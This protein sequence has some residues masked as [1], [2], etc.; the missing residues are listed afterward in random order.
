ME[1]FITSIQL[2]FS[3]P[4]N[5]RFSRVPTKTKFFDCSFL[6]AADINYINFSS[7]IPCRRGGGVE[8]IETSF[9]FFEFSQGEKKWEWANERLMP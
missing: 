9:M 1:M 5:T 8:D 7:G 2:F 6:T 3:F 4:L